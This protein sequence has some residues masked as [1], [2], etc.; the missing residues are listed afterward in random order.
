MLRRPEY[1]DTLC[2]H[3][4]PNE[5]RGFVLDQTDLKEMHHFKIKETSMRKG[6]ARPSRSDQITSASTASPNESSNVSVYNFDKTANDNGLKAKNVLMAMNVLPSMCNSDKTTNDNGL[7][8]KN[9]LAAMNVLP[10]MCKNGKIATNATNGKVQASAATSTWCNAD[11]LEISTKTK[12]VTT[13]VHKSACNAK[14][15]KINISDS[16]ATV[17]PSPFIKKGKT[18]SCMKDVPSVAHP[19]KSTPRVKAL[20]PPK[21]VH[22]ALGASIYARDMDKTELNPDE[23][24]EASPPTRDM[25]TSEVNQKDAPLS[26]RGMDKSTVVPKEVRMASTKVS[27]I[28]KSE[29]IL[30]DVHVT[31]DAPPS[32]CD[33]DKS[34]VNSKEVHNAASSSASTTDKTSI[35]INAAHNAASSS[36]ST[37]DNT[38]I[39]PRVLPTNTNQKT[40]MDTVDSQVTTV[41]SASSFAIINTYASPVAETMRTCVESAPASVAI[42]DGV[43]PYRIS[44]ITATASVQSAIDLKVL[45]ANVKLVGTTSS[46]GIVRCEYINE[47][48]EPV[49]RGIEAVRR[50]PR[51]RRARKIKRFENQAT[52]LIRPSSLTLDYTVNTKVFHNGNV[53]MTGIKVYEDGER[54]VELLVDAIKEI[55]DRGFGILVAPKELRCDNYIIRLINSDFR[56]PFRISNPT[57][58]SMMML[59]NYMSIY[60]PC[61]YQGLKILYFWNRDRN[62]CCACGTYCYGKTCKK[63]TIAVFQSGSVIITGATNLTMLDNAY[64]FTK[65]LLLGNRQKIEQKNLAAFV[66]SS[67]KSHDIMKF[68]GKVDPRVKLV[69]RGK[70]P[71]K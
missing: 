47:N 57:F 12:Q 19:R 51:R 11:Q 23:V 15:V 34:E 49:V 26:A 42:S 2:A 9:V 10:S 29:V 45:F 13:N 27:A 41:E 46:A 14:D 44:T 52:F 69:D 36:A 55:Q 31:S 43:T 59:S 32:A 64:E 3:H 63:I 48:K 68:F 18:K 62:G 66:A 39:I 17:H 30:K 16:H 22:L 25:D 28:G 70:L 56:V 35:I 71:R 1:R 24:H 60:E 37:I 8:A 50:R 65:Q 6:R 58:Q 7:K 38:S 21:D 40:T 67:G 54:C 61:I 4:I 53:Q 33:T 5:C 20:A